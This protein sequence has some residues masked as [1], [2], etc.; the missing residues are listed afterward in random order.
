[1]VGC[2]HN[3]RTI[4]KGR[5]S[6]RLRTTALE[7]ALPF[8]HSLPFLPCLMVAPQPTLPAHIYC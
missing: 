2:L 1:M 3:M 5:A 6:G 7:E 4:L 8:G